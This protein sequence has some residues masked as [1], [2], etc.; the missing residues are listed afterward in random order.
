MKIPIEDELNAKWRNRD[1]PENCPMRAGDEDMC[2]DEVWDVCYFIWCQ[3]ELLKR[4]KEEEEEDS[5]DE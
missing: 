2:S 3:R 4:M 1:C 5:D